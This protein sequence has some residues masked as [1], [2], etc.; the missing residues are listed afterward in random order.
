LKGSNTVTGYMFQVTGNTN[1]ISI[2]IT[3]HAPFK[4]TTGLNN[5]DAIKGASFLKAILVCVNLFSG[6]RVA[7]PINRLGQQLTTVISSSL[8]VAFNNPLISTR[9]GA[10]H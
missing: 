8:P 3:S 7:S 9:Q 10:V 2:G 5:P 4:I 6:G 1:C